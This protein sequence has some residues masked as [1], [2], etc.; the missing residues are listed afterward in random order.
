[1]TPTPLRQ[2]QADIELPMTDA[3]AVLVLAW[4]AWRHTTYLR[5][6]VFADAL[7]GSLQPLYALAVL[8]TAWMR[9]MV[10]E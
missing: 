10:P 9:I 6:P 2:A 5:A 3:T 7:A 1:M 4:A 8:W